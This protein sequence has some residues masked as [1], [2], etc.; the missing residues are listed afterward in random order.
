[1][2]YCLEEVFEMACQIERNGVEFYRLA[3][4]QV[5]LKSVKEL[6]QQLAKW[7]LRHEKK[8]KQ[9]REEIP[10]DER[11]EYIDPE[12]EAAAYL[13]AIVAGTV[14]DTKQLPEQLP[15]S[16]KE[17]F[18][19]AIEKEKNSILFYLGL[20]DAVPRGKEQVDLI[21]AEEMRHV[22]LLTKAMAD[23]EARGRV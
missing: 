5:T 1:M 3:A 17:T 16:L 9:M 18:R 8:F 13:D 22:N 11:T 4:K 23:A 19:S 2:S 12:D 10:E 21:I 7:E 20:K 6:F 15:S 14:F